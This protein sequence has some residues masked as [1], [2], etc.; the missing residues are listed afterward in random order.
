M[1]RLAY[2]LSHPT[3]CQAPLLRKIAADPDISLEVFFYSDF[4]LGAYRDIDSPGGLDRSI[5]WDVPLVEGYRHQFLNCWGHHKRQNLMM[6]PIAKNIP[7]LLKMGFDAIWIH[8]W[9]WVCSLQAVLAAQSL[10]IPVLL[11]G[12]SNGLNE[13]THPIKRKAKQEF[14]NWLFPKIDRFLYVGTLNQQFYQAHGIPDEKLFPM[15]Y[16]VDNDYFRQ[17]ALTAAPHRE[18]LRQ[19]LNLGPDRPI[20]LYAGRLIECKH[21]EDLLAAYRSLSPDGIQ[22]PQPYLLFVG[23]GA[24]RSALEIAAQS[25]GWKSIRFLGFQNQ[26]ALPALYELCDVF[27]LP[28]SF[29]TWGL[30]INE[31]MNAGKAVIVSNQVGCG[32]DLV[33]DRHNGC[34]CPTGNIPALVD[35]I[36]WAIAH[37]K[38][39]GE[40]SLRRIETWSF[41]ESIAG[42]KQS[43]ISLKSP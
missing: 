17:G 23:E 24:S 10:G 28:S 41:N 11:R 29:E 20:I 25:T 16:V 35:A 42:L 21:P 27:V 14:L 3:Q 2:F 32:S 15:P 18:M 37:A 19:S 13:P 8:G 12:T 6:Q 31:V 40:C 43:L 39:A 9:S 36:Q 22:E 34:V 1:F 5:E 4:S 38:T 26:S 7:N 30:T 33:L